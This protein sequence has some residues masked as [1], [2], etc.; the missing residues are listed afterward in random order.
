MVSYDRGAQEELAL[1]QVYDSSSSQRLKQEAFDSCLLEGGSVPRLCFAKRHLR[2]QQDAS[3]FRILTVRSIQAFQ[4]LSSSMCVARYFLPSEQS[5]CAW[6]DILVTAYMCYKLHQL[7]S[8]LAK[9][10]LR[11]FNLRT[12]TLTVLL[13]PCLSVFAPL[14]LKP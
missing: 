14:L 6:L 1:R 7:A 10:R 5:L 11:D 9:S 8:C 3:A 12:K 13:L 4:L 2:S